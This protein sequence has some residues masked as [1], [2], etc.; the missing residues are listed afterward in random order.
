MPYPQG[1][2]PPAGEN[3]DGAWFIDTCAT[4]TGQGQGTGVTWIVN[5]QPPPP[6]PPD[7]ALVAAQADSLLRLATPTLTVSPSANA[8]VNFPEWLWIDSAIWKS[9]T[10]SATACN[11]GGCTTVAATAT[12]LSVTWDT[13]DQTASTVCDYPGTPYQPGVPYSGQTT[14]C[15]HTYTISSVNEPSPD[16]NPNDASFPIT[17]T[18]TWGVDLGRTRWL[19]RPARKHH[20]RGHVHLEGGPDRIRPEMRKNP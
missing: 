17:A 9:V 1:G 3:P 19:C 18:V 8:Y 15:S 16:G 7:P 20:H 6:P 11:A 12:P 5:N 14:Q 10:T 4:G 13:G 2:A